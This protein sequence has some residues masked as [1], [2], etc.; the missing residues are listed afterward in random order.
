MAIFFGQIWERAPKI[1]DTAGNFGRYEDRNV[2][3]N[4]NTSQVFYK[5][6]CSPFSMYGIMRKQP[7][8]L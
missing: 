7:L 8:M 4:C 5:L 6:I 3:W 1:R 2:F